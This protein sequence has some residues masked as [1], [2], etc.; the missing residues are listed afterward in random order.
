M[1]IKGI[2]NPLLST[3]GSLS[4]SSEQVRPSNDRAIAPNNAHGQAVAANAKA[5][6]KP[7]QPIAGAAASQSAVPAEAPPGTDPALWSVLTSEERA[8]FSKTAAL[9]PL[10]YGRLKAATQPAAPAPRGVRL[11]VRA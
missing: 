3:L 5:A 7:Q 11:D 6:L 10:T 1:S 4:R 2:D 8:F 9:G